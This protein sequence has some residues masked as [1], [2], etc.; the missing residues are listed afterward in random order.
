MH[1]F[2]IE[3]GADP[4]RARALMPPF[5]EA[6]VKVGNIKDQDKIAAKI[7]EKRASH[8]SDWLDKAALRPETGQVLA[9]GMIP[10]AGSEHIFHIHQNS[11]EETI[12]AF[13]GFF[14]LT[15][16]N[17]GGVWVG[18]NILQFDLPFLVIR[19][20]ILGLRVPA[21]LRDGRF[22]SP[23]LF[24]DTMDEWLMGRR[25]ECKC[26]LDYVARSLDCGGKNGDG[27]D[28]A[29][30][31]DQDEAAALAYLSNDLKVTAGVAAKLGLK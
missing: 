22:F 7:E 15:R 25:G 19:S 18:H 2:D 4:I 13:W 5:D 24:C 6:K 31:Y 12:N 17:G 21:R 29:V 20:R 23:T 9:I 30:L 16:F 10:H 14:D 27:A 28:F 26:T 8:E 3:T 1:I 11:E